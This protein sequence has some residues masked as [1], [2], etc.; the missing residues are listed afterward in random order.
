MGFKE[1]FQRE[2]R[3][4]KSDVAKEVEKH[5]ILEYE[6]HQIE[7]YNRML[8]EIVLVDGEVIAQKTRK[9]IWSHI[10]PYSL[11][12]GTFTSQS[13]RVHKIKVKLGGFVKLNCIVK[14]DGQSLFAESL[15]LEFLSWKNKQ[16]IVAYIEQQIEEN[17]ALLTYDLPDD[18]YL[19]DENHPRLAPGLA[20]QLEGEPV[21]PSYPKKLLKLFLAQVANPS[22]ETRR[23]TY[24][25]IQEEK[26]ISYYHSF[27]SYF[28]EQDLAEQKEQ[29]QAEALWLLENAAH[30]EVVKFALIVLG[31]TNCDAYVEKLKRIALHGEFTG[32]ALFVVMNATTNPNETIFEVAKQSKGWGKLEALNFLE[33]TNETIR[34]WFITDGMMNS[35][36][37]S[38]APLLCAVKGKLDIV[39]HED[40]ISSE[41][42]EGA[43]KLVLAF[44][45]NSDLTTEYEY[46]GQVFKRYVM[47]AKKHCESLEQLEVLVEIMDYLEVS[48]EAWEER[49]E[50]NWKPHERQAVMDGIAE[51][52]ANPRWLKEVE[53]IIEEIPDH[54]LG[55][56][57]MLFL[58][59]N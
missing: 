48:D 29:I 5:W 23:Q 43:S 26:V 53:L 11:L 8:E 10:M 57:L 25:K 12:K 38:H 47:H 42:F 16:P 49:F 34:Q 51:I 36:R 15:K 2:I 24:E 52:K 50:T 44:A 4:V 40:K 32:A 45:Q 6:G 41:V 1:D 30:R 59:S 18:V 58:Q 3:N 9:S 14:V 37:T 55:N 21:L 56:H 22:T 27:L 54:K 19:Y 31:T 7:I 33:P 28:S 13:G 17:G 35:I 46:A 20:D 39:L